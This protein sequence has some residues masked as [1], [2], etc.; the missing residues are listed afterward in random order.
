ME[1]TEFMTSSISDCQDVIK[2]L[3]V[4]LGFLS[5]ILLSPLIR[6][7]DMVPYIQQAFGDANLWLKI[8][9][10]IW[11]LAW[12]VSALLLLCGIRAKG[13]HDLVRREG[14]VTGAYYDV[15]ASFKKWSGDKQG[16]V[17]FSDLRDHV[18]SVALNKES[19]LVFEMYKLHSIRNAK[20][21]MVNGCIFLTMA[22]GMSA[23]IFYILEKVL[24]C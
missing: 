11:L 13:G 14:V 2:S 19:E 16:E 21:K 9:I 17:R 5:V 1:D 20:Q 8:L 10:G 6:V 22:W 23:L 12:V 3:D 15:V 18:K 4:K 7:G 24:V